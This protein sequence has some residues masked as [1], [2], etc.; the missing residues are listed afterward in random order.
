MS[1]PLPA[2]KQPGIQSEEDLFVR[3]YNT[4]I[5]G[6]ARVAPADETPKVGK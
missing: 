6:S 5:G 4:R 1:I 2:K 3:V